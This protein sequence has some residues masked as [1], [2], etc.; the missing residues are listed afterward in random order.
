MPPKRFEIPSL[1]PA[2]VPSSASRSGIISAHS[3]HPWPV[4]R[5]II[6]H[7]APRPEA[8]IL[9]ICGVQS[10]LAAST[11]ESGPPCRVPSSMGRPANFP[12]L[13]SPNLWFNHHA[14]LG[15]PAEVRKGMAVKK[16]LTLTAGLFAIVLAWTIAVPARAYEAGAVAGGGKIDGKVVFNY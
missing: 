3:R 13:L 11:A 5:S 15:F 14:S 4:R 1:L 2:A 12:F 16:L 7:P 8:R 6:R 9:P 10:E